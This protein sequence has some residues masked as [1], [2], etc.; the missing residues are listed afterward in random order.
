MMNPMVFS[1]PRGK[2]VKKIPYPLTFSFYAWKF[3]TKEVDKAKS[4]MGIKICLNSVK[5]P[6]LLF[7]DDYLL[8]CKT[9]QQTCSIL[10]A[11]LD[12]FCS[13]SGQLVNFHK[14]ALTFSR[15]ATTTQ[16]QSVMESSIFCRVIL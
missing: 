2:S 15:N 16:K 7:A 12:R 14:S 8:F 13:L 9:N 11:I 5:I 4:G 6:C 3:L 1:S 10:K